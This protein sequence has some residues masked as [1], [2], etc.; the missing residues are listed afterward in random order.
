MIHRFSTIASAAFHRPD[1]GAGLSKR[2][3]RVTA[4]TLLVWGAEDLLVPAV[5]AEEFRSRID[6][7]QVEIIEHACHYPYVEQ[8]EAVSRR[9]LEFLG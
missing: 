1:P 2:L 5:Y 6:D 9:V 7:A 4:P 3:R 8:R